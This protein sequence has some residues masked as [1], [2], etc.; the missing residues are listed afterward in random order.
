MFNLE[1]ARASFPTPLLQRFKNSSKLIV[2]TFYSSVSQEETNL[3]SIL[4]TTLISKDIK[5]MSPILTLR[6]YLRQLH[7]QQSKNADSKQTPNRLKKLYAS[8]N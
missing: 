5:E 6:L 1:Q 3:T 7:R 8:F 2:K 4:G